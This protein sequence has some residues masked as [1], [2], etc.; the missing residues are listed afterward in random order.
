MHTFVVDSSDTTR[1]LK[2]CYVVDAG[3]VTRAIKKIWVIDSSAIA[4]L[5]F[6]STTVFTMVAGTGTTGPGATFVG[7]ASTSTLSF[8]SIT[9]SVD[10]NGNTVKE[11]MFAVRASTIQYQ[12]AVATNPGQSYISTLAIA[13]QGI[14]N[15]AAASYSYFSGVAEWSWFTGSNSFTNG[16]TYTVSVSF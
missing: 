2:K 5:V 12:V 14:L 4:R 7:F 8:G 15:A 9:P 11:M 16:N 6:E 1:K 13:G 3:A 10:V